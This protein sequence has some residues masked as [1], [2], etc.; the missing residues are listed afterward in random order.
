MEYVKSNK[1]GFKLLYDNYTYVKQKVLTNGAVGWECDQRRNKFARKAKLHVLD[2]QIIKET[3]DH[4][5]AANRCEVQASKVRQEMKKI[6]RETE[7]TPQQ[8]ISNAVA[9]VNNHA[10]FTTSV[11]TIDGRGRDLGN[12]TPVPQ[13]RFFDIP[14]EYQQITAGEAF[15]LHDTDNR[16][17]RILVFAT[18]E[19]I[20][21]L[22]ESQ[23][24]FTDGTFKTSAE[25]FFHI[26]TIHSCTVKRV[27]PC[28]LFPNKQQATRM[29]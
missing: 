28:A 26:Y 29:P 23:S 25:L 3:N 2:D 8:I 6:A 21:L 7:E 10:Q 20:Q 19:N 12:P 22:A 24:W 27:L 18:N 5:H 1:G 14:P 16:D 11:E 17:D 4:T 15:F 9:H 13:D